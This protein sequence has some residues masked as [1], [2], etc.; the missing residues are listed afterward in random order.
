[1]LK[2]KWES[3]F[4]RISPEKKR[5]KK[6][7]FKMRRFLTGVVVYTCNFSILE[8]EAPFWR[9]KMIWN[10]PELHSKAKKKKKLFTSKETKIVH[11]KM[12]INTNNSMDFLENRKPI[13][14]KLIY[15]HSSWM[16]RKEGAHAR[17]FAG[18]CNDTSIELLEKENRALWA[19][20]KLTNWRPHT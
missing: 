1:M 19:G 5:F 12:E 15:L 3:I 8:T 9:L 7:L 17:C 4:K 6:A 10:Q 13:I 14:R 2:T 16:R 11:Y 20:R 18:R